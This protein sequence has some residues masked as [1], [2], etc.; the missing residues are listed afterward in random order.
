MTTRFLNG[1]SLINPF[2]RTLIRT[3]TMTF[4][5]ATILLS[6]HE[7]NRL[8][9]RFGENFSDVSLISGADHLADGRSFAK[10]DF[11]QD[12][13]QDIAL[14]SLNA[15]RF[16]LYRNEM[17]ELFPNNKPFRFR[18]VGGQRDG[19]PSTEYSS[20]DGVGTRVLVTYSSGNKVLV[21]KQAGEGFASQN[22]AV[23]SIGIPDGDEVVRLDIRWPSGKQ[24]VVESPDN[25]NVITINEREGDRS[26]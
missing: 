20:R 21:Q 19:E 7:R 18:L 12:G 26:G 2:G 13:W 9:L 17:S 6:G 24:S 15:P 23:R 14:M 1:D 16:Q 3:A 8:L 25:E 5:F 11:D 4:T 10:L 22:S